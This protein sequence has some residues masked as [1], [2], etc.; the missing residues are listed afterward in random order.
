MTL[1]SRLQYALPHHAISRLV[2]ALARLRFRPLAQPLMRW[3]VRSY[4]VDLSDA[5][6]GE[7]ADYQSFNDLFTRELADGAR[8][9]AGDESVIVSPVDGTLSEFGPLDGPRLIQAKGR[10]YTAAELLA[11][12]AMAERFEGGTFATIYLAPYNYHRI[13][14]PSAGT[15]PL[16]RLV[17]GR[18]FS[19]N[20]AT[21]A[22]VDRLFARNERVVTP[23]EGPHGSCAMVAVGAL[24]VGSIQTTWHGIVTPPA[25]RSVRTWDYPEPAAYARGDTWGW[26]N[27]GSTV[28]LLWPRGAMA[29]DD[30]LHAG[31]VLRMGERLG[32]WSVGASG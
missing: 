6:R 31:Q 14:F 24:N 21:A 3:F 1:W 16:M 30:A 29:L 20:L 27:L 32:A 26:F 28:I 12:D 25:G 11:D 7:V 19:V 18:L 15:V 23:V 22:S 8:P 5:T 13:H 4:G 10:H 9:L 17:P 2:G